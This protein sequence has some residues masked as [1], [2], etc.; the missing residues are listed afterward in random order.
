MSLMDINQND[1]ISALK[2]RVKRLENKIGGEDNMSRLL[3][4]LTGHTVKIDFHG[5]VK[6][7]D[8]DDDWIKVE[9]VDRKG[10]S[11]IK[12]IPVSDLEDDTITLL[13]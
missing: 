2:R 11:T 12:L 7:L 9:E 13:D 4:E 3:K 6:V 10:A 5:T 8:C 1:E